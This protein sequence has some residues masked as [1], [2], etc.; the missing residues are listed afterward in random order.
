MAT[1]FNAANELA[2]AGTDPAQRE[3]ALVSILN[4]ANEA[5]VALQVRIA[6][7]ENRARDAPKRDA[8]RTPLSRTRGFEKLPTFGGKES[9][10]ETWADKVMVFFSDEKGLR[11]T[12]KCAA[13]KNSEI[14]E[15]FIDEMT[16]DLEDESIDVG[17]Y[18]QQ[19]HT[20][21]TLLTTGTPYA[22]TKNTDGNGYEAW[23]RLHALY[24]A[25][26]PQ[27]KR[28]ILTQL[29]GFKRAKNY[30]DVLSVQEEWEA[31]YQRYREVA[32][33]PVP[34]DVLITAYTNILP[35]KLAESMKGLNE[36]LA[37]L[38]EVQAYVLRQVNAHREPSMYKTA[39]P[40]PMEVGAVA[41]EDGAWIRDLMA[42]VQSD[43]SPEEPT[44]HTTDTSQ[45]E[46]MNYLASLVQLGK[47]KG[48]GKGK[49]GLVCHYCGQLG[50]IK[51]QCPE[52]DK[53]M[54]Q[55]RESKGKGKGSPW[56]GKG[57]AAWAQQP[58]A[59]GKGW[60]KQ[61][62][63]P[64]AGQKGF[65][66][67]WKGQRKGFDGKAGGKGL[68]W[69]EDPGWGYEQNLAMGDQPAFHL[70]TEPR[71]TPS[72]HNLCDINR[73]NPIACR[74]RFAVLEATDCDVE[75]MVKIP[76]LEASTGNKPRGLCGA[77]PK[78]KP[79][80]M[81]EFER[82]LK[83]HQLALNAQKDQER[84]LR[85]SEEGTR[86]DTH[87]EDKT[88]AHINDQPNNNHSD[89][90]PDT[91]MCLPC[92]DELPEDVLDQ[93]VAEHWCDSTLGMLTEEGMTEYTELPAFATHCEWREEQ[94]GWTRVRGIVDSGAAQCVAPPD[95]AP[96]IP[97][98]PSAGSRRGQNY[99]A[100]NGDR[101]PNVG[102]QT[103]NIMTADGGAA[104]LSFQITG[105]TRPLL[106]VSELA[107]RGNRVIFG[108]NGGV[109]QN[110]T[111]GK[112]TTF[113]RCGGVYA[114][115]IYIRQNEGAADR[116]FPRQG[117][118]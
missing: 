98:L 80:T 4:R 87:I 43:R 44:D 111:T 61:W 3:A 40:T 109:I 19:L 32:T 71:P 92:S 64:W 25:I 63:D 30:D 51:S 104:A 75:D 79:R 21:L 24:A 54:N 105:V 66:K 112:L 6:E 117:Q 73:T 113:P 53:V 7:L 58:A 72:S 10:F 34:Q 9:E 28:A 38:K 83:E 89:K 84:K 69:L 107:D 17:W 81:D 27:G 68:H 91:L 56:G 90:N 93:I 115:D 14:T 110:L 114:M 103:L 11:T 39:K 82:D 116:G 18:S 22:I 5:V 101:M 46:V 16:D 108:K 59:Y 31:V 77:R 37:T 57:Q 20:A 94:G 67:G 85:F 26:T 99:L 86:K 2:A 97:I 33:E 74:N 13:K 42:K 88:K 50:H 70:S 78:N 100:A 48:K 62:Q 29:M 76:T 8:H 55:W 65:S 47:G 60:G 12:L 49:A 96:G 118:A 15:Q 41:S 36:D 52:L 95:M 35:E 102:E 1:S 45:D 106:A 23:R